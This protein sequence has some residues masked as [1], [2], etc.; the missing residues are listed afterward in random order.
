MEVWEKIVMVL[1]WIWVAVSTSGI[2][3]IGVFIYKEK[4]RQRKF[5]QLIKQGREK[6]AWALW[7]L[8][9]LED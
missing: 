4:M 3:W 1:G 2:V 7:D 9:N 5:E 8:H 6:E